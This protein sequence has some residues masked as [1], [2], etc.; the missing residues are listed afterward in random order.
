MVL[1]QTASRSIN[2][3]PSRPQYCEVG[4]QNTSEQVVQISTFT[5]LDI[6][7]AD[8]LL[9]LVGLEELWPFEEAG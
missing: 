7:L 2:I 5:D 6:L 3:V 8:Q 4:Q 1:V 9:T